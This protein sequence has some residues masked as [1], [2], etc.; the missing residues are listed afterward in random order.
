MY[1][2]NVTYKILKEKEINLIKNLFNSFKIT[3]SVFCT[4]TS[5]ELRLKKET[6]SLELQ[7]YKLKLNMVSEAFM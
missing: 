4:S 6:H 5:R 1:N 7:L 2:Y 3:M